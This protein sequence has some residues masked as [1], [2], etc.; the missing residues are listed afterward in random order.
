MLELMAQLF[1]LPFESK[2]SST[3]SKLSFKRLQA[4]A[5]LKVAQL[6]YLHLKERAEEQKRELLMMESEQREAHRK[7]ELAKI[8]LQV[9]N[10]A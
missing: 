7:I 4:E 10:E 5:K 9:Y 6:E 1:H 2:R 8:E 3:S